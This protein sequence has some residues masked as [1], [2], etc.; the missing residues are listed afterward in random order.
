MI[1]KGSGT[2][3]FDIFSV[4]KLLN[5]QSSYWSFEAPRRSG[6]VAMMILLLE[7]QLVFDHFLTS[8]RIGE[9]T[10]SFEKKNRSLSVILQ[11]LF[12]TPGAS[13]N[14]IDCP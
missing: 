14:Y 8:L 7:S 6:D 9:T 11:R 13:F 12:V 2:H 1:S 5:Q 3:S 10:G 4:N